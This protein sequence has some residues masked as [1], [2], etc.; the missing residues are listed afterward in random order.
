MQN[1]DFTTTLLFDQSPKEVFDAINNVSAWWSEE[2]EGGTEKVN[3]VFTYH[4]K[5]VH[6]CKM[7]LIEVVP[8]TKVVWLVLD[9]HFSFTI[10]KSEWKNTEVS[11]EIS[12]KNDK[13]QL[14]FTHIGLVPD[15]ECYDVCKEGWSNYINGSLRDL[16]TTGKGQ[17]NPK[18]GA[19]FN[20]ELVDKW[21]LQ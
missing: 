10:D 19:G 12:R 1:Q 13:T 17:P 7:K 11:F 16:I 18:E 21:K 20:A 3:D 15:Y 6:F 8:E 9:N 2:V 4:Y 14:R 5:D